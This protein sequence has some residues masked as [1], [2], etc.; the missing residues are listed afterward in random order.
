MAKTFSFNVKSTPEELF[1]I[2]KKTAENT[3]GIEFTGNE[4]AGAGKGKGFEGS[5]KMQKKNNSN[6]VDITITKKP[7][8][9]PWSLIETKLS[10]KS[11]KW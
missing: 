9:I 10:E 5:Y 8:I 2:L 11:A 4:K 1:Q 7:W 6:Q 3:N